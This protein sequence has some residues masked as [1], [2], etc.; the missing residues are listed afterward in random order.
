MTRWLSRHG[1]SVR[2]ADTREAP[3]HAAQLAA[4]L[5]NVRLHTGA[6]RDKTFKDVDAIAISPGID[7]RRAVAA[8]DRLIG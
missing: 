7:G 8:A 1:P 5:P 2:V 4:Q 6:W 3:P